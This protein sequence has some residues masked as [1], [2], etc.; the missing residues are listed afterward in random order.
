MTDKEENSEQQPEKQPHS[1]KCSGFFKANLTLLKSYAFFVIFAVA[2]FSVLITDWG[3]QSLLDPLNEWI[4]VTSAGTLQLLGTNAIANGTAVT[5]KQLGSVDIKEGCNGVYAIIIFLAGVVAY[6]T[7]WKKK[8]VGIVFGSIALF[9]VNN[10]RVL[11]LFY[12][13][14]YKPEWFE[15]AHQTIWQFAIILVGGLLW[16]IWYDKVVNR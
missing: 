5:A 4:A 13:V 8:L 16:L 15:E 1:K 9:I 12:L 14:V 3:Q 10:I 11:T 6:P 7:G 2:A